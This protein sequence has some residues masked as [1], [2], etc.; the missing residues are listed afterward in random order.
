MF[1]DRDAILFDVR[2]TGRSVPAYNCMDYSGLPNGMTSE[3]LSMSEWEDSYIKASRACRDQLESA[4]A[5]LSTFTSAAVA[6]DMENLRQALGY[7]QWNVYASSNGTRIAM[8]LMRD[9]PESLRSVV[10]DSP[11]PLQADPFAEQAIHAEQVLDTIFQ[12]CAQDE[13]CNRYYPSLKNYFYE[14]MDALNAQPISVKSSNLNTGVQSNI[15]VDGNRLLDFVLDIISSSRM[16][17]LNQVPR[18]IYQLH[19][20]KVTVLS[21]L[22]SQSN[23]FNNYRGGVEQLI[24][25]NDEAGTSSLDAIAAGIAQ[26][27]L[28]LQSYFKI[29]SDASWRACQELTP[30]SLSNRKTEPVT[31]DVPTLLLTR[32][33][34]WR[35]PTSWATLTAQ[36]LSHA[37]TVEF[38]GNGQSITSFRPQSDCS[39]SIV[40]AFLNEP[41]LQPDT[42]CA[43][44]VPNFVWITLP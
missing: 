1:P 14:D 11:W 27:D 42:K 26:A 7:S 37:Y 38:H 3:N 2:G 20:N 29:Y 18:M 8:S 39:N 23:G 4:G 32:D 10:L 17:Q 28:S 40:K 15:V 35:T 9:Y 31:S 6:A 43:A 25:C 24:Q 16:D 22:L 36:T 41:G 30:E 12:Y 44:E 19:D 13:Q 34:N 33:L 5:N 21:E